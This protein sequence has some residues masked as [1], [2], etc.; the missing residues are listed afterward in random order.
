M[1]SKGEIVIYKSP[2]GK[3]E[4]EVNLKDETVWLTLEQIA[5]LFS[6]VKSTISYHISSIYKEKELQKKSTVRKFRTVQIEGDREIERNLEYYNLDVIISVGYRVKS[7]RGTQ[8]RIW[9]NKVLIDYLV[10]G[11]ALNEKRLKE[12]KEKVKEL[13]KSIEVPTNGWS[14]STAS[15]IQRVRVQFN[16]SL[17]ASSTFVFN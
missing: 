1:Q 16:S 12:Q 3:T 2:E 11:Y 6:K 9:A 10:K 8:F 15:I 17:T 4:L 13:E 5:R 14:T 7:K